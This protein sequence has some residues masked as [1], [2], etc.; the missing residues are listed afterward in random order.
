MLCI[1]H[2]RFQLNNLLTFCAFACHSTRSLAFLFSEIYLIFLGHFGVNWR[3]FLEVEKVKPFLVLCGFHSSERFG[4][5]RID[6]NLIKLDNEGLQSNTVIDRVIGIVSKPIWNPIPPFDEE[7]IRLKSEE[8]RGLKNHS[9]NI[10]NWKVISLPTESFLSLSRTCYPSTR[11]LLLQIQ[12]VESKLEKKLNT[13]ITSADDRQFGED[14]PQR[15]SLTSLM[16]ITFQRGQEKKEC[17][18]SQ[19]FHWVRNQKTALTSNALKA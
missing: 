11:S 18:N 2:L 16:L 19:I 9:S 14:V 1:Q 15:C 4:K 3:N 7:R 10:K 5:L 8:K 12:S 13:I 6:S 17:K